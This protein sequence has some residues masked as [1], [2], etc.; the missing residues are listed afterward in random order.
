MDKEKYNEGMQ[1]LIDDGPY[2]LMTSNPLNRTV[3]SAKNMIR[4]VVETMNL[5]SYWKNKLNV[6][7]PQISLLYGLL[8][9]YKEGNKM[10]PITSNVD[11]PF[12]NLSSLLLN[13]LRHIVGMEGLDVGN[14]LILSR[15]LKM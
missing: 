10:R 14:L 2:E 15:K 7:N 13:E 8:K 9:T 12:F 4:E 11:S 3:E 5:S 6:S 1:R